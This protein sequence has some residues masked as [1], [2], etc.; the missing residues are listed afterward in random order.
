[1]LAHF[2]GSVNAAIFFGQLRYWSD[3]TENP[4]GVYK[5]SDEWAK[6]TGLS[7]REQVTARRVLSEPGFVLETN[8]R[9]EHRMFFLIDW[10]AFN[11]A[12]EAW[13]TENP[14]ATKTSPPNDENAV[15]GERNRRSSISTKTTAETTAEK[16]AQAPDLAPTTPVEP[17]AEP[18][19]PVKKAA[20]GY[21]ETYPLPDWIN[22][23]HWNIWRNHPKHRAARDDQKQLV[24]DKLTRWR[25]DGIDTALALE[26]SATNNWQ[27]LFPPDHNTPVSRANTRQAQRAAT[28]AGLTDTGENDDYYPEHPPENNGFIDVES[29]FVE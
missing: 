22:R 5:T 27:G 8:K 29:R 19:K 15:R 13:S 16:E 4:L 20:T 18:V 7:Y 28:S 25:Q 6:E 21:E 10:D 24:I 26:N 3:R 9:L 17:P 1:M 2:F 11:P 14:P 12:F 23:K